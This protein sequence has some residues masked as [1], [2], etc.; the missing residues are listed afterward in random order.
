M[1]I[2]SPS[3][4]SEVQTVLPAHPSLPTASTPYLGSKSSPP[5]SLA[6][7]NTCSEQQSRSCC[8]A[9]RASAARELI[10]LDWQ[11]ACVWRRPIVDE[12]DTAPAPR[13]CSPGTAEHDPKSV[14]CD[15]QR[16]RTTL[17]PVRRTP[18]REA[19][20]LPLDRSTAWCTVP[21]T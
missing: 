15:E 7:G 4:T 18:V 20:R 1:S 19:G 9:Q 13:R 5:S 8:D 3:A 21:T 14:H 10:I 17:P 2:A 11:I 6:V 16:T 12:V